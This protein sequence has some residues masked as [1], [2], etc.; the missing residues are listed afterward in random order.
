M[1]SI[2]SEVKMNCASRLKRSIGFDFLT[3]CL[4]LISGCT[5]IQPAKDGWAERPT[6]EKIFVPRGVAEVSE[7]SFRQAVKEPDW[8]NAP[9]N[10][11]GLALSGGGS[12]A[13]SFSMGVLAGLDDLDYFA[14]SKNKAEQKPKVAFISSVSGGSYAAYFLFQKIIT[15][16]LL[17]DDLNKSHNGTT[18]NS[19]FQ[20]GVTYTHLHEKKGEVFDPQ[21]R[22]IIPMGKP[23]LG[24]SIDDSEGGLLNRYQSVV[25][26][27]Q[28]ILIPGRCADDVTSKDS[29]RTWTSNASMLL[30]TL[31]TAPAHHLFNSVFDT[32]I[33]VAPTRIVYERGIGLT[34]GSTPLPTYSPPNPPGKFISARL[35]CPKTDQHTALKMT[36]CHVNDRGEL[37]PNSIDFP[38]LNTAWSELGE[39]GSDE[40][41]FW[42]IQATATKYRSLGG[43][44]AKMERDAF[45][46]SFEF[47]PLSFGSRRYG[48]VPKAYDSMTV[49]DAVVSSAAF[50]DANQQV[51]RKR[52]QSFPLGVVQ[53]TFNLNWG[54][55]IPNYNVS[56]SRR[57]I[58]RLLPLPIA[59]LDS[60]V[61]NASLPEYE[62]DRNRSA[63]IRLIDGGSSENTAAI[64]ALRRGLKT[65]IIVDAAED[66]DG[67]FADLCFLKH[68]LEKLDKSD[69]PILLPHAQKAQEVHLYVPVLQE[70]SE[71]CNDVREGG[72]SF[73]DL[74]A[75]K[76]SQTPAI[77]AC[78]MAGKENKSC[79]G[80]DVLTRILV[81]KPSVDF[82]RVK[83]EWP[84]L[85]DE[86]PIGLKRCVQNHTLYTANSS[87]EDCAKT[88]SIACR[89]ALPCEVARLLFNYGAKGMKE[90][91][92][93]T[94]TVATT[95]NSSPTLYASYRELARQ[96][97]VNSRTAVE[98]AAQSDGMEFERLLVEQENHPWVRFKTYKPSH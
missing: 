73:Y 48:F 37:D 18:L 35:P 30:P 69:V 59:W 88:G 15:N 27:A 33:N 17:N 61:D 23:D 8:V 25:R 94:T 21:L 51:Y 49:L 91:F 95:G 87:N 40:L 72:D 58:H 26:C 84:S 6:G 81:I 34:Y 12:K 83:Q 53:H 10:R 75:E 74:Q 1:T 67:Q 24:N 64:S 28:D 47:T 16:Q 2:R 57:N 89:Q 92:P 43:W 97:V 65:L 86:A 44:L 20:D 5:T 78:L 80:E 45:I 60:V 85:E 3:T 68:S 39:N 13:G 62:H 36:N 52:W 22:R 32:G 70:F 98:A 93:Q 82:D 4:L 79:T 56:D 7:Q 63:F 42:V 38:T 50:F 31:L 90:H 96:I 55:D 11:I 41:P 46:D 71:H 19:L 54:K 14:P 29:A 76:K 77:L 9:T 66:R